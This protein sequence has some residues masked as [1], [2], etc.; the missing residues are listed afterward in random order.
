MATWDQ[1]TFLTGPQQT[2]AAQFAAVGAA[3][4]NTNPHPPI[5]ALT[6]SQAKSAEAKLRELHNLVGPAIRGVQEVKARLYD[7][8]KASF[9]AA[10]P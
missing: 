9:D 8:N 10:N 2:L 7:A 6:L 3:M 4:T 1:L 5:G